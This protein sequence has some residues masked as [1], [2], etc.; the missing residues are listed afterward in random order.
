[1]FCQDSQVGKTRVNKVHEGLKTKKNMF[2]IR[3]IIKLD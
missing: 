2:N 3:K 1:M